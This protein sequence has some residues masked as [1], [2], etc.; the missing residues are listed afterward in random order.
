MINNKPT[1]SRARIEKFLRAIP[2]A[3]RQSDA[4]TVMEIME[5]A[6]G[7][8][9][10]LWPPSCIGFGHYF[11]RYDSGREGLSVLTSFAP[12]KANLVVY[13]MPG[14]KIAPTLMAK[15]GKYKTGSSCLYINKLQDID[16]TILARLITKS[17]DIMRKRYPTGATA[18]K[19]A[20]NKEAKSKT[21]KSKTA[22]KTAKKTTKKKTTK[23][24]TTKKKTTKKKTT[25]RPN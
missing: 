7:E 6:T 3:T 16:T 19:L 8:P 1:T 18:L 2:N 23:K 14:F 4:R 5:K 20:A 17:V 21:T 13:I 10:K 11:Y 15:L 9:P 12:R 25:K 22:K 24:K